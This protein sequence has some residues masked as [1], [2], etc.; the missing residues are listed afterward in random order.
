MTRMQQRLTSF[1]AIVAFAATPSFVTPA[2][3]AGPITLLAGDKDDFS[4]GDAADVPSQRPLLANAM[5]WE[6]NNQQL[7]SSVPL[8]FDE[9][10]LN[11]TFGHTFE[12]LAGPIDLT[13]PVIIEIKFK[14]AAA[15]SDSTAFQLRDDLMP[16]TNPGPSWFP[17]FSKGIGMSTYIPTY[18]DGSPISG[19][20]V[21]QLDLR[22][23]DVAN[24]PFVGQSIAQTM[25]TLGYLDVF[26]QDD[27]QIDYLELRYTQVP[28]PASLALLG[29]AAAAALTRRRG[30]A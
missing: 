7:H 28:E 5:M 11:H 3:Q 20:N 9:S 29:L 25:N 4:P 12:N 15:G 2:A 14:A 21:T 18:G 19:G 30:R 23:I 16:S 17:P 13:Q 8:K 10:A 1:L 22:T 24:G 27:A 6:W 26:H